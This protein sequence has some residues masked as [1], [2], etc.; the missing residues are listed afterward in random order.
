MAKRKNFNVWTLVHEDG[1]KVD[2]QAFI[3]FPGIV[4]IT[5]LQELLGSNRLFWSN[6]HLNLL[7]FF[8]LQ[9]VNCNVTFVQIGSA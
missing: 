2:K 8:Q 4:L 7:G 3:Y 9:H 5:K 1:K 6:R